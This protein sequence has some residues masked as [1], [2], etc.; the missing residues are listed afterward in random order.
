M[1][2]ETCGTC[3]FNPDGV[4]TQSL[5]IYCGTEMLNYDTCDHWSAKELKKYCGLCRF[6][7]SACSDGTVHHCSNPLSP[8]NSERREF[9]DVCLVCFKS[10]QS[11]TPQPTAGHEPED[12]MI[13][14]SDFKNELQS[15]VNKHSLENQSD[16]PDFIL[17]D[18]IEG[19]L[20]AFNNA[21][22][23]RSTWYGKD[24]PA[25]TP[26]L[27]VEN[28]RLRGIVKEYISKMIRWGKHMTRDENGDVTGEFTDEYKD[29]N[30]AL[31]E[32][33]DDGK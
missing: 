2:D 31:T 12:E 33:G 3:D 18:F 11:P 28:E 6:Y 7:S 21:I 20:F 32:G 19:C 14:N 22:T 25:F 4:C 24:K 26:R 1:S 8:Y 16:T 15:L 17:A 5:S 27:A 30:S 9:T 29:A 10:R 13:E 23:D